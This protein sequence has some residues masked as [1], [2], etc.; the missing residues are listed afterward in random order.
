[1]KNIAIITNRHKDTDLVYTNKIKKLLEG[2]CNVTTALCSEEIHDALKCADAA[3]VLGGDGTIL[4]C[5]S[6]AACLG[7]P[8][9]GINLGTLGFLAEVEKGE[10]EEAVASL[11]SG[12]YRI[13]ERLMLEARVIRDGECI[14]T[15]TALNDFVVSRSSFRRIIAT[16]V[17]IDG[18]KVG[19]YDGDGLIVA[20]PT[21]STG[22]NLSAGG[23]ITDLRIGAGVITPI[24]PRTSFSASILVPADSHVGIRLMDDFA[25][26]SMLTTDG[27]HGFELS[28]TDTIEICKSGKNA[29]LIKIHD[30]SL[31][32]VLAIK[33][34]TNNRGE[35]P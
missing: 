10:A 6:E 28:S 8:V 4:S 24:C 5:A 32:E 2:S 31:Y 16:E 20:T 7:V 13:E 30:R 27:Q 35:Q 25:K 21:G 29:K 23:P 18:C 34:I 1:M 15:Q 9:M 11:L 14:Y 12:S 17:Y 3:I 22:Y 33:N 19:R 26:N